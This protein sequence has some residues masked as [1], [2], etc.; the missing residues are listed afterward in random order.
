[1]RKRKGW[2]WPKEKS[3]NGGLDALCAGAIAGRKIKGAG[4]R[5]HDRKRC[6]RREG[7][8]ESDGHSS[9]RSKANPTAL[10]NKIVRELL[11]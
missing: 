11:G 9:P 1:M 4:Q 5:R 3:G 7:D 6:Q 10:V 2:N 8:W